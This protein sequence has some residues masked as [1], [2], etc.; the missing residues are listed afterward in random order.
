M[1]RFW[2]YTLQP[3][4]SGKWR[5]TSGSPILKCNHPGGDEVSHA[6]SPGGQIQDGFLVGA[7]LASWSSRFLKDPP[8]D[9]TQSQMLNV[10]YIYLHLVDLSNKC[11][12]IYIPWYIPYIE[13]LGMK[14]WDYHQR[15]NVYAFNKG[16]GDW[17]TVTSQ[18][19]DALVESENSFSDSWSYHTTNEQIHIPGGGFLATH[20]QPN[21]II[22]L[23]QSGRP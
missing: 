2:I 10:R 15:S 20:L 11:R 13:H 12:C 17:F 5:F 21:W 23:S 14:P 18:F 3:I 1:D 16:H 7:M 6:V 4:N 22:S 8:W 19:L 9:Q